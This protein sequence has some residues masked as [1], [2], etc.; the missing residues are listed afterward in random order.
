[1]WR[2]LQLADAAFPAGGFAHSAG[3]EAAV[4]LGAVADAA[5]VVDFARAALWQAG[6]AA[7]PFVRAARAS[8]ARAPDLDRRCEATL[9]S[10]VARRA[11]RAQG[12]AWLLA[13]TEAFPEIEPAL[14]GLRNAP[15]HLCVVF[16]ATAG[17]LGIAED[18]AVAVYLHAVLRGV[19]SAGV[20]L[21]KIGPL[22]AQREQAKLAAEAQRVLEAPEEDVAQTAPVLELYGALHDR[23]YSRLFQS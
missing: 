23:L 18:D 7:L 22:E 8:V 2:V 13:A 6:G 11:S 17:A 3:L 5:G 19:L 4:Q 20:R 1:M 21:G 10:H 15:R 9:V 14:V 16:G 12:R